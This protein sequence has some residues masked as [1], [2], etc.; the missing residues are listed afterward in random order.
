MKKLLFFFPLL[1]YSQISFVAQKT[2]ALS[3]TAEVITIQQP[4]SGA[5]L[6]EFKSAYID[7]SVACTVTL[8]RGGNGA[9]TSALTA[10]S[11]TSGSIPVALAFSGSDVGTGTVLQVST[12]SAGGYIVFDLSGINLLARNDPS[13][14]FTLRTSSMTG[15]VHVTVKWTER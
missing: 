7:C 13:Q 6:V 8:E 15:T 11:I 3:S 4:S 2:T 12:L 10:V 1:C 9:T 5:K 14:N